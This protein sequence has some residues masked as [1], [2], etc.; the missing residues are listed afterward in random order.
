MSRRLSSDVTRRPT[1]MPTR[2]AH[3]LAISLDPALAGIH[4]PEPLTP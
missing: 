2:R 1:D 4:A 3:N